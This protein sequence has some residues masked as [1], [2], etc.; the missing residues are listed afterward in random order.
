LSPAALSLVA[1]TFTDNRERAKA[2]GV[3]SAVAGAGGATGVVLGGLLTAGP[4]WPWVFW[5]NVP[6]TLGGA[7]LAPVLLA[8]WPSQEHER[9][10]DLVGAATVTL[11]LT[12]LI[13]G[14][15]AIEESGLT[16]AR[17]LVSLAAA[18][19]LLAAFVVTERRAPYPLV[20]FR[21][22]RLRAPTSANVTMLLFAAGVIAMSFFVTLYLQQVLRYSP[23]E[24]GL[25]FLPMALGQIVFSNVASRVIGR[26]GVL[27][28]LLIGLGASTVA[29]AWFATI[30]PNGSFLTDVLGPAIVL[31]I[32]G[33]F[34]FVA[35]IMA[36]VTGV[37]GRDTGLAGGLI[38]M[39]QQIGGAIGLAVLSTL[40]AWRSASIAGGEVGNTAAM[41]A[42]FR[43]G[44]AV[45]AALTFLAAVTATVML[46]RSLPRPA[47]PVPAVGEPAR[48]ES[49]AG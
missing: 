9:H 27:P 30:S 8:A 46:R 28:T 39:S 22:F 13:Y 47:A 16:S 21:M 24:A 41:T 18:V 14:L 34:T 32:G 29:F 49:T 26:L 1:V 44:F 17:A 35:I 15:V 6:F 37:P 42:G 40:A 10:F 2:M 23:V 33:G 48:V 5:V 20:P 25:S 43:A 4:G 31:S 38:N 36:A 3:W 7:L 19:V 11:G 45:A 12:S